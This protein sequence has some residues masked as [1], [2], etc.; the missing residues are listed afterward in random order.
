M[1]APDPVVGKILG[2]SDEHLGGP[3]SAAKTQPG[4]ADGKHVATD[5]V[6]FACHN[7]TDDYEIVGVYIPDYD[8]VHELVGLPQARGLLIADVIRSA[9]IIITVQ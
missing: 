1:S 7:R 2:L 8:Q 3:R 6:L 9:P 5:R 4:A